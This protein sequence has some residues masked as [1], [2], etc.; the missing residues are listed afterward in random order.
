MS[1]MELKARAD[2]VGTRAKDDYWIYNH[3]CVNNAYYNTYHLGNKK[4][5][6]VRCGGIW[7]NGKQ[8][9]GGEMNITTRKFYYGDSHAWVETKDGKVIDWVIN[10][11]LEEDDPKKCV[12]TMS[13]LKDKG[14]EY[15]YY[16]EEVAIEKKLKKQFGKCGEMDRLMWGNWKGS[17]QKSK[18]MWSEYNA[19]VAEQKKDNKN[20][21]NFYWFHNRQKAQ[22]DGTTDKA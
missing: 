12:W 15:R 5:H 16:D 7:F 9:Y 8:L 11:V 6:K 3:M 4:T 1:M 22:A 10:E 19:Y 13:E 20:Y 18:R 14:I 17:Q 2:A 21:D